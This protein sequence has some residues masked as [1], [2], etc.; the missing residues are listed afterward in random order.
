MPSN[1]DLGFVASV[2]WHKHGWVTLT[3]LNYSP[4]PFDHSSVLPIDIIQDPYGWFQSMY[5]QHKHGWVTLRQL[6]Y[7][8]P[9]IDLSSVLP[10]VIFQDPY[11]WFKS[12]CVSPYLLKWE[13]GTE[14]CPNF[15]NE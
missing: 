11:G 15:V 14:H 6:N 10:I 4:P 1:P 9:P 12:M 8:P 3:Q 13:H 5:E 7:F 2:R